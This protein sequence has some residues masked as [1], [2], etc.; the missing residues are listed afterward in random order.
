MVL[1]MSYNLVHQ[2][3]KL[4]EATQTSFL[5]KLDDQSLVQWLIQQLRKT[6]ILNREEEEATKA[7]IQSRLL[8]IRD[9]A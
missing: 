4:I 1:V 3:W 6:Q 2:I 5:L 9:V 7:Y 8:L